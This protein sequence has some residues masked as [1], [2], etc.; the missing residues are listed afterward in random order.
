MRRGS[1]GNKIGAAK[2]HSHHLVP[3]FRSEGLKITQR[4]GMPAGSHRGIVDQNVQS[5]ELFGDLRNC[6]V[7]GVGACLVKTNGYRSSAKSLHA[8][9]DCFG[10][11]R[12]MKKSDGDI[13]AVSRQ[14]GT[15][16]F[17]ETAASAGHHHAGRGAGVL[18]LRRDAPDRCA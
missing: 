3:D 10:A 6:C 14:S 12:S 15:D 11:L 5:A 9:T 1:A 4:D 2:V 7:D 16:T 8:V 13:D 17:S 18:S